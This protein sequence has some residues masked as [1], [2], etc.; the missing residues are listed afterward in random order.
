M[1]HVILTRSRSGGRAIDRMEALRRV[2]KACAASGAAYMRS[3]EGR[4][5]FVTA[6]DGTQVEV[7]DPPANSARVKRNW[8]ILDTTFKLASISVAEFLLA[9]C[10][11]MRCV[12][13]VSGPLDLDA[14]E[15]PLHLARSSDL[16]TEQ[17]LLEFVEGYCRVPTPPDRP[18]QAPTTKTS[19]E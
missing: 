15:L 7:Y 10:S 9:L 13:F 19:N 12:S 5:Y 17:D 2:Q 18:T 16:I 4:R 1:Y 14:P 8:S 6:S 3:E 11:E